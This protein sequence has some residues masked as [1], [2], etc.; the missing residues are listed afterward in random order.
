[1]HGE[2]HRFHSVRG[3]SGSTSG[4]MAVCHKACVTVFEQLLGAEPLEPVELLH[5]RALK[6]L[7]HGIRITVSTAQRFLYNVV[8]QF[9]FQ[10]TG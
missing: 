8:H 7:R 1:M 3:T 5:Q 4:E 10:Q 2:P 9:Q 6:C